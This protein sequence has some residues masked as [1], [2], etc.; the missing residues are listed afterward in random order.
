MIRIASQIYE[1]SVWAR[2]CNKCFAA[3]PHLNNS[4]Q[5]CREWGPI[6][7]PIS[8]RRE[9]GLILKIFCRLHS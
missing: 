5:D 1:Y 3:L 9:V 4:Q 2:Y 7:I 6:I 8:W